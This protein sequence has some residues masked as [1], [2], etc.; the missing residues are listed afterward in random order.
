MGYYTEETGGTQYIAPSAT[1]TTKGYLT[2]SASAT[3]FA[4]NG[5]LHAH[6]DRHCYTIT[7]KVGTGI[8]A[9]T[10]NGWT[11]TGTTTLTKSMCYG[12]TVDLS[13]F[14]RTY[15]NGYSGVAY[16]MTSGV[17]NISGSTFTVGD[18]SAIIAIKATAI[19]APVST[20]KIDNGTSAVTKVYG[21]ATSTLS[22]TMS[23]TYDS[24]ISVTYA[25]YFDTNAN[26]SYTNAQNAVISATSHKGIRYYKVKVTAT[27]L[28]GLSSNAMSS[29][30]VS[31][32]LTR[33]PYAPNAN[34]CGTLGSSSTVY[35]YSGESTLYTAATGGS[36]TTW[37]SFTPNLGMELTGWYTD[38]SGGSKVLNADG[39]IAGA[40]T[41]YTNATTFASV[42]PNTRT[43]YAQCEAATYS[44]VIHYNSNSTA[45]KFTAAT[46]GVSCVSDS[47]G[48]C[49][50]A[51]PSSVTSSK[52]KWNMNYTGLTN[53][54]N[55]MANVNDVG[56]NTLNSGATSITL[57]ASSPSE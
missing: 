44:T 32:T 35:A 28:D 22:A 21:N 18:G 12:D 56:G 36:A 49:T 57:S 4:T 27:G 41:G 30:N 40:V 34:S 19:V 29:N 43:L 47:T 3:N 54:L 51:I 31:L 8:S 45:G 24:S 5:E 42:S 48:K 14:S 1:D 38:A 2:S 13:G 9:L 37:T 15:K 11:G 10:Y 7:V 26:G 23:T 33:A 17:G 53:V 52:G 16:V 25:F 6:W 39:S 20:I 55:S 50:V 46:V